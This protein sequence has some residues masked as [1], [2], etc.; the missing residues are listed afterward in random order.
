MHGVL[1]SF[2]CMEKTKEVLTK[3]I[4]EAAHLTLRAIKGIEEYGY[5][6]QKNITDDW[7]SYS[8]IFIFKCVFKT[9]IMCISV[10]RS[11][12]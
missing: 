6:T 8:V 4:Y 12:L 5:E 10:G 2:T 1:L 3:L 11:Q 9:K 7:H